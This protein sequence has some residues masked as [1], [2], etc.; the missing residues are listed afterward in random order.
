[1]AED[2]RRA[3]P[4]PAPGAETENPKSAGLKKKLALKPILIVLIAFALQMAVVF[5]VMYLAR[6][7]ALSAAAPG[8]GEPAPGATHEDSLADTLAIVDLGTYNVTH[9]Q[10]GDPINRQQLSVSL[11][12]S[13]KKEPA[14]MNYT[15]KVTE[16]K[17][18]AGQLVD[19][20]MGSVPLDA[21]HATNR[22]P[23]KRQ[24]KAKLNERLGEDIVQE[25]ILRIQA[26]GP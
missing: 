24:L 20:V 6:P 26:F 10:K 3:R 8:P 19:E 23:L 18:W 21:I 2:T 12:V 17:A 13:V 1:M 14:D 22:E 5:T 25:V 9:F 11:A 15:Q 16:Q 7:R 4:E